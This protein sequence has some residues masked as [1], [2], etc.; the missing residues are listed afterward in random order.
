MYRLLLPAPDVIPYWGNILESYIQVAP[1]KSWDG[2]TPVMITAGGVSVDNIDDVTGL[3]LPGAKLEFNQAPTFDNSPFAGT[4]VIQGL[5]NPLAGMKYRVRVR[6]LN[7]SQ[8]YY[9]NN[10]L[11]LLGYDPVSN[12]IIHPVISADANNYYTYQ[13]YL[14]N[15][16]SVVALFDPG[17]NDLL[18]IT[19]EHENGTTARQR[20]RM[21]NQL[22][23]ITLKTE[24]G[25]CGGYAK[26]SIIKGSFSVNDAFLQ[27]YTLSCSL[28]PGNLITGASNVPLP[29]ANT[30]NFAFNT[31]G[32]A[33]PCGS[34]NLSATQ[35]TIHNS[36]SAGYTVYAGEVVC[37]K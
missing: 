31:A 22:P 13:S 26:G 30:T 9:L 35:K 37:L 10:D 27:T 5:S 21:D 25:G 23:Q 18:E 6:N 2:K 14:N 11:H 1:G 29:P 24:Y 33:S 32:S 4:I 8:V 28:D 12:Q 19:M 16:N 36:V 15:I 34:I 7:T 3:S 17:T 20:I